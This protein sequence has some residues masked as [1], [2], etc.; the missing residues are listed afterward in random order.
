MFIASQNN[1]VP[2]SPANNLFFVNPKSLGDNLAIIHKKITTSNTRP[3][4]FA[5]NVS[6]IHPFV[7]L[8]IT[9]KVPFAKRT[10]LAVRVK[11]I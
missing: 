10:R 11:R 2:K 7:L 8:A 1:K 6:L 4:R 9:L 3:N 5:A